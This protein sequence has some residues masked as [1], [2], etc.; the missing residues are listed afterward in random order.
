MVRVAGMTYAIE[1]RAKVGARISDLRLRGKPLEARKRYKVAGWAP[2]A[3]QEAKESE[4]VWD[5]VSRYLRSKKTISPLKVAL[6]RLVNVKGNPG[7]AEF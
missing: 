5:V 7:L 1:P 6:P 2:V 4:P 3:A